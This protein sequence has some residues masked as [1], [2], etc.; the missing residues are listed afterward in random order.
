MKALASI[1]LVSSALLSAPAQADNG[2]VSVRSN[3]SVAA[4]MDRLE[5][6]V[7]DKG[8]KVFARIDHAAG[9]RSVDSQLRPTQLLIFGNPKGGTPFMQCAQSVAIDLPLKALAWEDADGQVW[10]SYNDP[11][12]IAA[13]HAAGDCPV[14]DR[15]AAALKAF[16]AAATGTP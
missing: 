16:S 8:M 2:L 4:T 14:V 1:L 13:R 10:L 6:I 9:A 3:Q 15:I 12:W 5:G 11:A 7:S